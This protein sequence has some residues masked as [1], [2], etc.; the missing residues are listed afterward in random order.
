MA[1]FEEAKRLPERGK[2]VK[3]GQ[4]H[5]SHCP[6]D[7]TPSG[8]LGLVLMRDKVRTAAALSIDYTFRCPLLFLQLAFGLVSLTAPALMR[9]RQDGVTKHEV[10]IPRATQM[11]SRAQDLPTPP[12]TPSERA[13]VY[14]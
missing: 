10:V 14:V 2:A 3:E 6:R 8:S 5:Q 4:S 13:R 12:L 1:K 11:E 7:A 9:D